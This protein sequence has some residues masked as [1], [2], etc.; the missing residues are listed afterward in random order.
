MSG[1][2]EAAKQFGGQMADP[3]APT[4]PDYSGIAAKFGGKVDTAKQVATS[5][6]Q[7]ASD[8]F[9]E[10][11]GPNGNLRGSAIGGV[12]QGMADPVVGAAQFAANLPGVR[13]L[14]GESVNA[15]IKAKEAEYEAA[16]ARAGRG[17]FDAA[18]FAGNLA[19]PSNIALASRI[20]AAAGLLG[21]AGTGAAAGA[22]GAAMT[23]ETDAENYWSKHS[24]ESGGWRRCGGCSGACC[25]RGRG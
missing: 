25:W 12:M 2:E 7:G 10:T 5:A 9:A 20:P 3:S 17:G 16:R 22:V 24:T 1:Y 14:A 13:S 19:A 4:A 23:P 8:W 21:R 18:R 11:F 6:Y 15:G